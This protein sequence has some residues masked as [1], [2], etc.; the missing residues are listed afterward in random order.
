MSRG[1]ILKRP[2]GN[3]AI[4]YFDPAGERHYKTVGRS[5]RDAEALLA[6][7]L[8]EQN[9]QPW[10]QTSRETLTAYSARW[11]ERRDP[12]RSPDQR[13]GRYVR[14]R[15]SHAT[16]R[17]YARSLRLYILPMLGHRPIAELTPAEI[18]RLIADMEQ[19]GRAAGTIRN[20]IAPLRKML[21]DAHRQGLITSNPASRPDL[22]PAQEFVG[23]ELP[24]EHT[25]AIRQALVDLA[26][27]NPL[28]RA[29][30][31]RSGFA[32]ST[33]HSAAACAK[34]NCAHC[35]GNTSTSRGG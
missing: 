26:A 16:H 25:Q 33:S 28:R 31:I 2:N 10:R 14:T 20:T 5:R 3:Y 24:H 19:R 35:N 11:L 27:A 23:Q 1:Q 22:P 17:E 9:S 4:R 12:D 21:G 30:E 8:H 34:A 13:E 6:Q 15:I 18:D 29:R 7:R 32:T